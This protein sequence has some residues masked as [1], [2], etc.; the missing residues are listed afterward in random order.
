MNEY[1]IRER[2]ILA[3]KRAGFT[4]EQLSTKL[5]ISANSYRDLEKGKTRILN[6]KLTTLSRVLNVSL[7]ELLFGNIVLNDTQNQELIAVIDNLKH[8]IEVLKGEYRL[9]VE[10]LSGEIKQLKILLE[11]KEKI[12]G[13]LKEKKPNY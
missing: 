4:Q 10:E 6:D 13:I 3:R 5:G 11:S 12:I 2:I 7:E 8:E 9:T 1:S